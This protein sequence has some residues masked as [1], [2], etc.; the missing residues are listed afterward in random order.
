MPYNKQL[1][2]RACSSRTE[3][4]WPL[5]VAVRTERSKVRTATTSGQYSPVRPS[6]SVSK[7]L[8]FHSSVTKAS[9]K[10]QIT[11]KGRCRD[12]NSHNYRGKVPEGMMIMNE[13]GHGKMKETPK[14]YSQYAEADVTL[15]EADKPNLRHALVDQDRLL[16]FKKTVCKRRR[17]GQKRRKSLKWNNMAV[18]LTDLQEEEI[19]T[20]FCSW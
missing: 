3:E 11:S 10:E 13:N 2:N 6:R 1:T 5:V 14:V 16:P 19:N 4:Y 9:A 20:K 12:K 7:R 18:P 15:T 8:F 17:E